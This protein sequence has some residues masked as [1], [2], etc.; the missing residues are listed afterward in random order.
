[1]S[2][3]QRLVVG[4]GET[5][6]TADWAFGVGAEG[7]VGEREGGD[8]GVDGSAEGCDL[9]PGNPDDAVHVHQDGV[10]P[11]GG[12]LAAGIL[13]LAAGVEEELVGV[14]EA[15]FGSDAGVCSGHTEGIYTPD[16]SLTRRN[17]R[18]DG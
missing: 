15:C 17:H 18:P 13:Q 9:V 4:V 2:E 14:G 3:D 1:P 6:T 8:A 7:V 12:N 16:L 11:G 5:S 10:L